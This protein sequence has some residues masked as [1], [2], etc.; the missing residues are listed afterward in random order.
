MFKAI[1]LEEKQPARLTELDESRL[2][3]GEVTVAVSHSTLNYKDGLAI[4]GRSPVVRRFPMVAGI[5]LAGVVTA[6]RDPRYQVGEAVL[7]NG[8][9]LGETH[10]GGLAEKARV[11][12]DW[13]N[14]IP[15]G[16][17]AHDA[18]A[19]G[20]AGYTAML[21]VM[22]LERHGVRPGDGDIVVTGA[23]GGVGSVATAILA[24]LGYRVVAV[25]GRP[26]DADYLQQL[27]AAE[28]LDRHPVREELG[29]SAPD[30]IDGVHKR[31]PADFPFYSVL[32]V[33]RLDD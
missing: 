14:R 16:M 3:E 7:V 24:R 4:T 26:A 25:T 13:L 1:Y 18:M 30:L 12:A 22:A 19:I 27:G 21:C 20:T 23:A 31:R 17:S 2:P 15:H 5:D 9:G 11:P 6:S 29:R 33:A 32:G 28:I 8:Q 10:W